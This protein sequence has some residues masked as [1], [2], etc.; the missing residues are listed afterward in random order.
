MIEPQEYPLTYKNA[1]PE[2]FN[3][4]VNE[5][6]LRN[7]GFFKDNQAGGSRKFM[8]MDYVAP[9]KDAFLFAAKK[10]LAEHYEL[11]EYIV[12]PNLKDFVGYITEG[13]FIQAHTDPDLPGKRHVRINVL[14][15]QPGG[16]LPMLENIPIAVSEGDAWLNLASLCLHSTSPVVGPGYRSAISFGYQISI[17]R[18]DHFY[19]IH[20]SW[21]EKVRQEAA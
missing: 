7:I 17:E 4:Y 5:L 8:K 14:V 11:G 12:P 18:C 16:C 3:T 19:A 20:K 13:G 6:V 15:K 1:V 10:R 2:E 9:D 21:M